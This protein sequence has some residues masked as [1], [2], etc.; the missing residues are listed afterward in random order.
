MIA[1]FT[2]AF[3]VIKLIF[4]AMYY[5]LL[6]AVKICVGLAASSNTSSAKRYTKPRKRTRREYDDDD[7]ELTIDEMMIIDEI[8]DD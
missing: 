3:Q 7:D 8:W 6:I 5:A 1:I 2:L 4:L